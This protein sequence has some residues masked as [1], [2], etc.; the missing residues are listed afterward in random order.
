MSLNYLWLFYCFLCTP[1]QSRTL[2]GNRHLGGLDEWLK[3]NP[4]RDISL[5]LTNRNF[6]V[7]TDLISN[8]IRIYW[9]CGILPLNSNRVHFPWPIDR[10]G[11]D[12]EVII[13]WGRFSSSELAPLPSPHSLSIMRIALWQQINQMARDVEEFFGK[14]EALIKFNGEKSERIPL[15]K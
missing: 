6:T 4:R 15:T 13:R 1:T 12:A 5:R 3:W 14:T 8:V 11:L 10:K 9:Q 7:F 2:A